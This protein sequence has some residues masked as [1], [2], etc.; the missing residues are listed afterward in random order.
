ARR[1]PRHDERARAAGEGGR[2]RPPARR[3]ERRAVGALERTGQ[4]MSVRRWFGFGAA[5]VAAS[6]TLAACAPAPESGGTDAAGADCVRMV[7][8]SGGLEDRSFNQSSW[9]GLQQAEDEL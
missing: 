8:N 5:L 6:V 3:V 9:E 4:R 1:A 7:T 2:R